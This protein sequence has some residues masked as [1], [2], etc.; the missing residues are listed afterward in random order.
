MNK[1]NNPV[2][3]GAAQFTQRK[4]TPQ[5]L[6]SLSLMVKTSQDAIKNTQADN[7]VDFIDA[8]YMVNISSWSYEDAPGELGE[9]L[10]ISP[11]EKIYLTGGGQSPQMLI[12]RAA[13]AISLGEHRCILITG[14]EAAYSIN[15]TF[16]GKRPKYWPEKKTPKYL[17]GENWDL[18]KTVLK[19]GI[20]FPSTPYAIFET[21]L[22]SSSGRGIE[23]HRNYM[24]KLLE[25]FSKVASKNPFSWT[26]KHLSAEEIITPSPENRLVV[27]PY[28]KRMCA[29]NFV[30]QAGTIIITSEEIAELLNID[31]KHW[32]YIM[33]GAELKNINEIYRRPRLDDS[34]AT[35][36]SAH[37]ALEQ[38]GLTLSDIDKFDLY[39]CFPSIVEIFM[40]ELGINEDDPRD[41]TVTGGLPFFGTPLSNYSLHAVINTVEVIR[42]KSSLK[43]MV[44]ANGGYNTKQSI[45]IYGSKP[46]KTPWGTRDDSKIQESILEKILPEP[47]EKANGQLIVKGYSIIYD[48]SG[49]PKRGIMIGTLKNGGRALAIVQEG[50]NIL[51]NLETQE[52][53]GR[54]VM[55]QYDSTADRNIVISME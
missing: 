3:I 23:E 14:G 6:D 28:T 9:K 16:K 10:N 18:P 12:N 15:K 42:S 33:G 20:Y 52:I 45:G 2:I 40:N 21:A 27:Y 32:V 19:Y 47:I 29:N 30:D 43:V 5:P 26:Q 50:S 1:K 39:S 51:L 8:I 41:L 22:R 25:R 38:A 11:K 53:V 31:R 17:N 7:I 46:P 13:K 54:T 24:G 35:R 48:R 49:Q 44:I 4:G 37:L 34:P 55:I 36:E